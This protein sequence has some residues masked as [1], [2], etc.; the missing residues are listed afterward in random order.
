MQ[1]PLSLSWLCRLALY[2]AQSTGRDGDTSLMS[3]CLNIEG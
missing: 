1:L 3:N 2:L